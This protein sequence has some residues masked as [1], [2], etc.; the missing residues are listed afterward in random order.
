MFRLVGLAA[1]EKSVIF[2]YN[3]SALPHVPEFA[4]IDTR[5]DEAVHVEA[6]VNVSVEV[7]DPRAGSWIGFGL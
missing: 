6:A 1:N 4:W 3:A 7:P 2:R 5:L